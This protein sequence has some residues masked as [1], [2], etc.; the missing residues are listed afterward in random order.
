MTQPLFYD[1]A[2]LTQFEAGVIDR[3]TIDGQC[4]LALDRTA[5]YPT[6]GGQPCD[7][8][9]L[10]DVKVMDVRAEGDGIW[11]I[12]EHPLPTHTVQGRI[13]WATRWDHMQ[14]HSG[15]H[16]LSQAFVIT[17]DA[18]TVAWRLSDNTV[19]ID[20][21]RSDL[22]DEH[23]ADAERLGNAIVQEDRPITARVVAEAEIPALALRKLP[24][25]AG[26]LRIVEIADFDRV[27][28]SGTHVS[29]TAQVGLIKILRAERRGPETRIHFVCGQ[30]ALADYA[31]KHALV[32][33]LAARL[34]CGEDELPAAVERLHKDTQATFKALK[35]AQQALVDGEANRL[36]MQAADRS[37]PRA[38]TG[39]YPAWDEE[40]LKALAM[41]LKRLPGCFI[42]LAGGRSALIIVARSADVTLDAGQ[43]LRAV[44]SQIGGRGGGRPDFAQGGAPSWEAAE[45]AIELIA[46]FA[47]L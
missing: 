28:C 2:Y 43:T 8:G 42:A 9:T 46:A 31:R 11:H 14:N 23:L 35:T 20:L 24:E 3:R 33:E 40:Q 29:A 30:R 41:A 34:T 18:A 47:Q 4:A 15:Q 17:S 37:A 12:V 45:N 22:T 38:I 32:R 27:A 6:G 10:N 7:K 19:T 21:L 26:P 39:L 1:H 16:I 36:W 25:V 44:L 5:F 13:D